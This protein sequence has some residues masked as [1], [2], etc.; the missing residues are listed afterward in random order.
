MAVTGAATQ[1][2]GQKAKYGI[3]A[4][5]NYFKTHPSATEIRG[6]GNFSNTTYVRDGEFIEKIITGT[7]PRKDATTRCFYWG[8]RGKPSIQMTTPRGILT[9]THLFGKYSGWD[10][11]AGR[12][13][14]QTIG[15]PQ[16]GISSVYDEMSRKRYTISEES[17][18]LLKKLIL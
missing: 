2:I 9:N 7:G 17:Y 12:D 14:G 3:Q 5:L 8:Y 16:N 6:K 1:Q 11:Y 10:L 13:M 18:N 15:H 4:A